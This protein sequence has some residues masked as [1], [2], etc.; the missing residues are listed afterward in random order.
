MLCFLCSL[1][2]IGQPNSTTCML[3]QVVF[4]I[5]FSFCIACVL[6]KT[7]TVVIAFKATMPESK[8]RNCVGS[9]IPIYIITLG[10]L[11]QTLI[12]II[13]LLTSPPFVEYNKRYKMDK[14][15]IECNEG[16]IVLFCCVLGYLGILATISFIVAFLARNLPDSFNEAKYITFSMLSFVCVWV[17]FVPAYFSTDGKYLV[18][19]EV[20]AIL[21]SSAALLS[22]IFIPKCYIILIRPEINTR[23]YLM[24]K[25]NVKI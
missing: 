20:F 2:F 16:S 9:R 17:S 15:I 24:G 19:V 14:I 6:A 1:I 13:W 7:I 12:C 4:S 23:A 18:A 11:I 5:V 22:C 3:Q 25:K 8:L 21:A 10:S